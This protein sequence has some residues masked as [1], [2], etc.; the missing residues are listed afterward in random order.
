VLAAALLAAASL[1]ASGGCATAPPPAPP[2][3]RGAPPVVAPPPPAPAP[4]PGPEVGATASG[5][6]ITVNAAPAPVPAVVDSAPSEEA[7]AVLRTLPEPAGASELPDTVRVPVPAPTEPLGDRPGARPIA[8]PP[9]SLAAPVVTPPAAPA[10]PP[11]PPA[12]TSPDP[13]WRVQVAA[14]PERDRADRM[15]EAARSQLM[16]PFVV[17]REAG[18][19]KVRTRDC[20]STAAATDLRRRA[21]ESGFEGAFRFPGKPR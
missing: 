5:G 21:L 6:R 14:P 8:A 19:H 13:C 1:L 17:E 9:E 7:L 2:A 4:T 12:G 3:A 20:L 16:L 10:T 15:A 18:L 11:A